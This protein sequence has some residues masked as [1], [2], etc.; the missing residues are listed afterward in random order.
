MCET[1]TEIHYKFCRGSKVN[2]VPCEL[3]ISERERY[4]RYESMTNTGRV[5]SG[6]GGGWRK[7]RGGEP[8]C[9]K[10]MGD[11]ADEAVDLVET[12]GDAVILWELPYSCPRPRSL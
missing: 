2:L 1:P 9:A 11:G 5:G 10:L 7:E 3:S 8:T 6:G 4:E 12:E